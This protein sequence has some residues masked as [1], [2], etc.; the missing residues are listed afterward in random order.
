MSCSITDVRIEPI[1]ASWQTE[2][3]WE[4]GCVADVASSLNNKYIK[5]YTPSGG[6]FHAWWNIGGAGVDPAPAGFTAIPLVAAVNA[7]TATIATALQTAVDA[8]ADFQATV[9][10]SVVTITCVDAGATVD[11][12]D[13]NTGF[14]FT[15][16]ADGL[17]LDLGL[18]DGDVELALEEQILDITAHQFGTTV[19]SAV[20]QGN[21]V[22]VPLTLKESDFVK[23]K[24][25]FVNTG[26][27]SHTPTLGTEVFGW[28][29]SKQ[30]TS[31]FTQ[32]KRLVLHPVGL[33]LIDKSRDRCIWKAY[34]MLE[35]MVFSGEN[36]QTLAMTFKAYRDDSKPEAISMLAFGDWTQYLPA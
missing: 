4:V 12:S 33:P 20:R 23:L 18:L 1:D 14:S 11:F 26:G 9:D 16:C 32:S 36:P 6:K 31:T 35:T 10:G 8:H 19:L 30:G 24:A 3:Q 21:S 27:G 28:G 22:E 5:L 2:E 17:Y 7:T 13:F 29:T 34:P 25:L 15:Q